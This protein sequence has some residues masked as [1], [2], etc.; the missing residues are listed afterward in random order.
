MHDTVEAGGDDVPQFEDVELG[1][2]PVR[3]PTQVVR[4]AQHKTWD[5]LFLKIKRVLFVCP[6]TYRGTNMWSF[7]NSLRSSHERYISLKCL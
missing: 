3:N 4:A 5:K 7:G 6:E 2:E 1:Q